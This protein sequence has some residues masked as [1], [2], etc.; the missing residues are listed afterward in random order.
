MPDYILITFNNGEINFT[1]LINPQEALENI[2]V[3]LFSMGYSEMGNEIYVASYADME[4]ANLE[5]YIHYIHEQDLDVLGFLA[6]SRFMWS[7]QQGYVLNDGES[8]Q[9]DIVDSHPYYG[10]ALMLY[11]YHAAKEHDMHDFRVKNLDKEYFNGKVFDF[12]EV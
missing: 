1:P 11:A 2:D 3:A 6:T 10:A 12:Y 9:I 4:A 7:N 8:I 5:L